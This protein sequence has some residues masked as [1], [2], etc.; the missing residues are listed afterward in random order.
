MIAVIDDGFDIGHEDLNYG[1]HSEIQGNG[2]DDDGNGYAD[3]YDGWNATVGSG[4]IPLNY[5]EPKS[6]V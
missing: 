4:T 6:Q 3:D 2:L 1:K 5:M